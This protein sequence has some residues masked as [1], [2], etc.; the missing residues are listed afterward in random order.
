MKKREQYQVSLRKKKQEE[1]FRQKR[2]KLLAEEE[3]VKA[4]TNELLA[5][6]D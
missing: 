2:R 3:S 4:E 1:E 6:I 5:S